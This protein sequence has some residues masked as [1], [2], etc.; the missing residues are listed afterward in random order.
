MK[1]KIELSNIELSMLIIAL[2]NHKSNCSCEDYYD[3]VEELQNK[4]RNYRYK[5]IEDLKKGV[6]QYEFK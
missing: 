1:H 2:E 4:L 3:M 6:K 5:I